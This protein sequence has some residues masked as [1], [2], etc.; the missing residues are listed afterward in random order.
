MRHGAADA[1]AAYVLMLLRYD[2]ATPL[3][4]LLSLAVLLAPQHARLMLIA[5]DYVAEDAMLFITLRAFFF[6]AAYSH[7]VDDCHMPR[8]AMP[9]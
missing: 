1:A 3:M 5:D 4:L 9:P 8:R 6:A 2:F 7:G